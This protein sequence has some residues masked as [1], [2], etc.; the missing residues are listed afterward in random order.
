[1]NVID[2]SPMKKPKAAPMGIERVM[3]EIKKANFFVFD[4][5]CNH[6]SILK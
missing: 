1:M 2:T 6:L 5:F 4:K 3:V